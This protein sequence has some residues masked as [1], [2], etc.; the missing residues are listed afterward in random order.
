M[1]A[2]VSVFSGHGGEDADNVA[3]AGGGNG[4]SRHDANDDAGDYQSHC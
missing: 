2:A 4:G 1:A 3:A